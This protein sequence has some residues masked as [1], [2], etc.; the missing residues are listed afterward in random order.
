MATKKKVYSGRSGGRATESSGKKHIIIGPVRKMPSTQK[1]RTGASSSTTMKTSRST[2]G[3]SPSGSVN[4]A[5]LG[6]GK[7][8]I[9]K[10]T[11]KKKGRK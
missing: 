6:K 3:V 9:F 2:P 5:N 8:V 1:V 10:K 7:G 11:T 4:P